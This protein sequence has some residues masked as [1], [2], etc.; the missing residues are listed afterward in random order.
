VAALKIKRGLNVSRRTFGVAMSFHHDM[1][2]IESGKAA[3]AER[4]ILAEAESDF[5]A[6]RL[7]EAAR[8]NFLRARVAILKG[9]R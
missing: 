7:L 6:V 8:E 3:E 2:E 9:S 5:R 1:V 4:A